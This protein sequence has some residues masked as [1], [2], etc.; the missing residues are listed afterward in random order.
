MK[1]ISLILLYFISL[2]TIILTSYIKGYEQF[3]EIMTQENGFFESISVLI[4]LGIF[5]YGIY[6]IYKYHKSFNK[7]SIFLIGLFSIITF[8]AAMEE[9]SWGQH[10][11]HFQSSSYFIEHN[12]QKE[13]NIHN[14]INAN[15]FSSIIYSSVYTILVFIP[16]LYKIILKKINSFQWLHCFDINSHII[17]IVLYASSFQIYFYNNFGVIFDFIILCIGLILFGYFIYNKSSSKLLKV[18]FAFILLS[19]TIFMIN[20]KVF[21]F[22][23]MQYEIREMFVMLAFLFVFIEQIQNHIKKKDINNV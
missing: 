18:H 4:L 20:Y 9:I 2:F 22:F 6:V 17:L 7:I 1:K 3:L 5:I 14:L 23:N 8:I 10:I 11:F 12:I 16:L 15:L 21:S 19:A 13:T